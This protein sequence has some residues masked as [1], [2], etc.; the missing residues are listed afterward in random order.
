MYVQKLKVF[1]LNTLKM[2][3]LLMHLFSPFS[4]D[5][6]FFSSLSSGNGNGNINS[7]V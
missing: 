6:G 1:I 7:F 4:S 5:F 2:P 3:F